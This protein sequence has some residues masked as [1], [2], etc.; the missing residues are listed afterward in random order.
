M[1]F[2]TLSRRAQLFLVD[3]RQVVAQDLAARIE[4]AR[5]EQQIGVAVVD[6]RARPGRRD[7][8]SQH[9]R[10]ALGIDREIE[11][12]E[13]VGTRPEALA[14]LQ[15]EQLF[16]IDRDRIR[17]DRRGSGDR[18]G[19]DL[20]LRHQALDAGLDQPVAELVEVEDADDQHAERGKVEE[21]DA[22]RQAGKDV[23]A[24]EALQSDAQPAQ[25]GR[26]KPRRPLGDGGRVLD[27][28]FHDHRQWS[29]VRRPMPR[30][31]GSPR[32]KA[33]RSSR[34]RHRPA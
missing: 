24:E 6:A 4:M 3:R 30:G 19:D 13:L 7:Q 25:V 31:T 14:G 22:P 17:L 1:N 26:Q 15:L 18:A 34:N 11:A 23:V 32:R 2:W 8:P 33:F 12:V 27:L 20:A 5:I 29:P 10:H 16:G 21:E 9:R 28:C